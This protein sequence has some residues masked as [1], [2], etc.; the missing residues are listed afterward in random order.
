V[1]VTRSGNPCIAGSCTIT[2]D[3]TWTNTGQTAGNITPTIQFKAGAN[4]V[5]T[6]EKGSPITIQ[7]NGGTNTQTFAVTDLDAQTYTVCPV[8]N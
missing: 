6:V 4:I 5:K 8:P 7:P 1:V 3:V 2:I